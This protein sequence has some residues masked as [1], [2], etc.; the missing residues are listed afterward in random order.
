MTEINRDLSVNGLSF[1]GLRRSK[2][3]KKNEA[4]QNDNTKE[5]NL[6][7]APGAVYGRVGINKTNNAKETREC[8]QKTVE[9][10]MQASDLYKIKD[11][12]F[13]NAFDDAVLQGY[14]DEEAYEMALEAAADF[15]DEAE[16]AQN[17]GYHETFY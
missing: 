10:F 5:T 2:R 11:F 4:E 14:S 16:T 13:Q 15:L 17:T 7:Q 12:V 3:A 1:E 8:V 6:D 9:D